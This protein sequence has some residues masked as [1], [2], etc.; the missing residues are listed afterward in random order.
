MLRTFIKLS[1]EVWKVC[2]RIFFPLLT[3]PNQNKAHIHSTRRSFPMSRLRQNFCHDFKLSFRQAHYG[4]PINEAGMK[5]VTKRRHSSPLQFATS[6][7]T[8]HHRSVLICTVLD[9]LGV[10]QCYWRKSVTTTRDTLEGYI[11]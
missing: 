10:V 2:E 5:V 4:I 7:D 8:T 11:N 3:E 9:K 1:L 6:K